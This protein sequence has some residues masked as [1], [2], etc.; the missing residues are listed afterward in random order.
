MTEVYHPTEVLL[1]VELVVHGV[2]YAAVQ[3]DGEH[4][5]RT[6]RYASRT[7][8]IAESVVLN[9]VAQTAAGTQ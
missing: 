5:L 3:V 7:E 9:L 2:L 4:A 1:V 8:S 6:C